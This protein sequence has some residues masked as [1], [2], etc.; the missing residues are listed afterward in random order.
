MTAPETD[1]LLRE[2]IAGR[3]LIRFSLGGGPPRIGEPHDYGVLHG[4]DRVLVFQVG[5]ESRSGRLPDWRLVTVGKISALEVLD[6]RFAGARGTGGGYHWD[7]IHASVRPGW[8]DAS[9]APPG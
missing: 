9:I 6:V 4:V 2:A 3:W 7:R 8:H 5:G 1:R